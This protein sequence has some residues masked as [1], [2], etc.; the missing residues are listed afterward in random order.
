MGMGHKDLRHPPLL[1]QAHEQEAELE[2]EWLGLK[3]AP[4]QVLGSWLAALLDVLQ[5][6]PL[7]FTGDWCTFLFLSIAG[8]YSSV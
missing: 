5:H 4:T 6:Q 1:S 3:A 7:G 2:V 8:W